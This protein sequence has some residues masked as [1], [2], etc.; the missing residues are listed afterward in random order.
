MSSGGFFT[1]EA[2]FF[3]LYRCSRRKDDETWRR[4]LKSPAGIKSGN[5]RNKMERL[6]LFDKEVKDPD[7]ILTQ[8]RNI[9]KVAT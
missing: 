1:S 2:N 3:R 7:G 5:Q 4:D 6:P 9:T 8:T